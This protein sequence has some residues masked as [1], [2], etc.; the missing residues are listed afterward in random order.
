MLSED[1]RHTKACG[2]ELKSSMMGNQRQNRCDKY[3]HGC[4]NRHKE[5]VAVELGI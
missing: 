5:E 3:I 1:E 4:D 2:E